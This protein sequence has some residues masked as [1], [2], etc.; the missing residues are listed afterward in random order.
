MY[1]RVLVS[2]L[3]LQGLAVEFCVLLSGSFALVSFYLVLYL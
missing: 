2:A 1:I 3:E